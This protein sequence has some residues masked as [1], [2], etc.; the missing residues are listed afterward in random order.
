MSAAIIRDGRYLITQRMGKALLPLLWEF[1]G[2]KVEANESEEAALEREL[3]YR[4]G[5][6]AEI[7]ERLSVVERD[8][9]VYVVE[10]HLF[11]VDIGAAEPRSQTVRDLRW[12]S[13]DEFDDYE[14]TPA[15]EES[16]EALLF[17][18]D[19]DEPPTH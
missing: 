15:D 1:P 14:F 3:R 18:E 10:L 19:A 12:V 17:G 9:P 13:S 8:Y 16:M 2:G 4:L 11:Y 7:G 5:V 6:E